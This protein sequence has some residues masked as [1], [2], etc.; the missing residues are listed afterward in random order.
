[1]LSCGSVELH[2]AQLCLCIGKQ[3]T[4]T[5]VLILFV[6]FTHKWLLLANG[7]DPDELQINAARVTLFADLFA[8][9]KYIIIWIF[10]PTL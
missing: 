5:K 3:G 8:G 2:D 10:P 6:L 4:Y 9:E 1:M 7:E